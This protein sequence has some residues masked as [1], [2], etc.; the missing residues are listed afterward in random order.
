M[1][2]TNLFVI[3]SVKQLRTDGSLEFYCLFFQTSWG[4]GVISSAIFNS[5]HNR[6]GFCTILVG[7]RNSR[8]VGG[9]EPP[10]GTPLV[11]QGFILSISGGCWTAPPLGTPLCATDKNGVQKQHSSLNSTVSAFRQ[12]LHNVFILFIK[13]FILP[14][15]KTDGINLLF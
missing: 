12:M 5:F 14:V 7:L 8:G 10:L 3:A 4:V 13:D 6:V 15:I 11:L 9:V 2:T 1:M